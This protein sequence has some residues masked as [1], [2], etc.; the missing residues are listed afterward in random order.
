[1]TG[2]GAQDTVLQPER[3]GERHLHGLKRARHFP[4]I[5]F[6]EPMVWLLEL[7]T[8]LDGL[9]E[10]T[11]FIS[12]PIACGRNLERGQR[13]DEACRQAPKPPLPRPASGSDSMISVQFCRGS[14][15]RSSRT[16]CSTPRL[17]ML[18]T[19]VRP[20]RNSIDR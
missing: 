7:E 3:T 8:M 4:G 10:N 2:N 9:T 15:W 5:G 17:M 14:D 1:M 16:N 13:I 18:L 20:I 19:S 11:V 12:Q 6:G